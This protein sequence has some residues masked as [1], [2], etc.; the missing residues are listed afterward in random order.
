M[1]AVTT[2]ARLIDSIGIVMGEKATAKEVKEAT[3]FLASVNITPD[4]AETIWRTADTGGI[5]KVNGVWLPNTEL[6]DVSQPHIRAARRAYRA[7]L[8][9]EV[10]DTI[11]KPGFERPSFVDKNVGM[12]LLTQFKSFALSSTQKNVMAGLQQHDMA[13][14]N[15]MMISLAMGALSYYLYAKAAGGRTEQIMEQSIKDGNWEL[16]ADE[17]IAR[18]GQTAIFDSV[19]RFANRVPIVNKFTSFSGGPRT[20]TIGGGLPEELLGPSFD[21]LVKLGKVVQSANPDEENF[22]LTRQEMHLARQLLP[23]QNLAYTRRLLDQIENAS[24]DA[25]GMEGR[26]Q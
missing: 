20:K 17:A 4:I 24:G 10:D 5:E 3:E 15:G 21:L 11:I 13:Y 7:A 6:W 19:Q 26:R 2:N 23:F 8:A 16:W 9:G 22:G 12:R 1:A 14:V 25:F 18:S